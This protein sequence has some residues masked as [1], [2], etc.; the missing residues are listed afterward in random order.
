MLENEAKG[1]HGSYSLIGRNIVERFEL[2]LKKD[3]ILSGKSK[4]IIVRDFFEDEEK[5]DN[6]KERNNKLKKNKKEIDIFSESYEMEKKKKI[7]IK[8]EEIKLK[9]SDLCASTQKNEYKERYKFHQSRHEDLNN[10]LIKI[11]KSNIK[12][13]STYNPKMDLIWKKSITGPN[14]K[15]I[16]GRENINKNNNIKKNIKKKEGDIHNRNELLSKN[17]RKS[18]TMDKQTKRGILPIS[19]DLRIRTDKAFFK[20]NDIKLD[21]KTNSNS[22]YLTLADSMNKNID[23]KN[24]TKKN[25]SII[26]PKKSKN[27]R[28]SENNSNGYFNTYS[29]NIQLAKTKKKLNTDAYKNVK[30]I[31]NKKINTKVLNLKK[32][33]ERNNLEFSPIKL[34]KNILNHTIDFSKILPRDTNKFLNHPSNQ[35]SQPISNPSYKLIEPRC[36]TM[37]SYSQKIKR[38]ENPKKFEGVDPQIFYDANKVINKINNHKEVNAPNFNIMA[39]RNW[40]KGPLPAFMVKLCDRRS[41]E[42][43]TDKGLRMNNYANIDFQSNYS[44]F[45][46]KKSF[47]KLVNNTLFK[48]DK[49]FVEE[50]LKKINKEIYKDKKL[51]KL[52][53]KYA[54]DESKKKDYSIP[55]LDGITLKTIKRSELNTRIRNKPLSFQF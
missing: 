9:Q 4:K 26:T 38:R 19:Y 2:L 43:I 20:K 31:I 17:I 37:I 5:E 53:E 1:W 8:N 15:L 33:I 54:K 3:E 41:L 46:P 52:I 14:W 30:L 47:N 49:V 29:Y 16:K 6:N 12:I 55:I 21:H 35:T 28:I 32:K 11:R 42:T 48:N 40:D 45:A 51:K 34:D 24:L 50:E 44:T 7:K 39:G 27:L 18:D 22:P 25:I 10:K 23:N 36:L 13:L